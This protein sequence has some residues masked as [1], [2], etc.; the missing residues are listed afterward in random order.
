VTAPRRPRG[1]NKGR[2]TAQGEQMQQIL[3]DLTTAA[4]MMAMAGQ[5]SR[6]VAEH[7]AASQ[8]G[9]DY[10]LGNMASGGDQGWFGYTTGAPT[11]KRK[12][13]RGDAPK[14]SDD[15]SER[16]RHSAPAGPKPPQQLHPRN[17]G[18]MA[19]QGAG[20]LHGG[21]YLGHMRHTMRSRMG[22]YIHSTFG[23]GAGETFIPGGKDEVGN[24]L[25][26]SYDTSGRFAGTVSEAEQG[27]AG[28]IAGAAT[29]A[30]VS[31]IGGALTGEGAMAGLRA[32][33]VLGTAAAVVGGVWEGANFIA[34][35]RQAN[36]QYQS[37]L[38]GS[39]MGGLG[40]RALQAGFQLKS[41]FGGG[42]GW[43]QSGQAFKD[44][45][46]LGYQGGNRQ[47][48]LNFI[49]TNYKHTGMSVDQSMEL[50]SVAAKGVTTNFSELEDQ[51]QKVS[52]AAKDTNQNAAAL[53]ENFIQN[54]AALQQASQGANAGQLAQGLTNVTAGL[55]RAYAPLNFT[56]M[57]DQSGMQRAA[58]SMGY[59]NLAQYEAAGQNN[60]MITAQGSQNVINQSLG[61]VVPAD[62]KNYIQQLIQQ[63]G[64][65]QAVVNNQNLQMVIAN[66]AMASGKVQIQAIRGVLQAARISGAEQMSDQA[67]VA[68]VVAWVAG[69]VDLTKQTAVQQ[70][71]GQQQNVG[72]SVW[73]DNKISQI[74]QGLP[75][76][77]RK[78]LQ[79]DASAAMQ[80]RGSGTLG[81]NQKAGT[82]DPVIDRLQKQ[83]GKG[84]LVEVQTAR[85]SQIVTLEQAAKD[86]RDQLVN[87]TAVIASGDKRGQTVKDL[88]GFTETNAKY[89][90]TTQSKT[91]SGLLGGKGGGFPQLG[92]MTWDQM[93][94]QINQIGGGNGQTG[95]AGAN[96]QTG[97]YI[98]MSPE[99]KKYLNITVTGD[100]T[101]EAGAANNAPPKVGR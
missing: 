43:G 70:A 18:V 24:Q 74:G 52:K 98:D 36:A 82:F 48:R 61:A 27:V 47:Q 65:N 91:T 45:T 100:P 30:R 75:D 97:V 90:D 80:G 72:T 59:G 10:I 86:F 17:L 88:V 63:H 85:G 73:T 84:L 71:M 6:Q 77:D 96:A 51:L 16:P 68:Y 5:E 40:Q 99:L 41:L 57:F 7:M 78:K 37:V 44:V 81:Y 25:Y 28:R 34:N 56:G 79:Q 94:N 13:T 60:P 3:R 22:E 92:R 39:N 50:V 31:G 4:Q 35:Q 1:T 101:V 12:G 32:V 95:T 54:F 21:S 55:G 66:Q 87:G 46:S 64:G 42:L 49:E 83:F 11:K 20:R 38:G 23:A 14:A 33:P 19:Y 89:G 69:G 2:A 8:D 58:A 53:R 26:H 9:L 29:R 67:V 76:A 93:Q 62:L 15:Q